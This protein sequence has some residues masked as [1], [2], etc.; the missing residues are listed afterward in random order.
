LQILDFITLSETI[1]ENNVTLKRNEWWYRIAWAFL[2]IK[3]SDGTFN[4]GR[5]LRLQL[6]RP[7]TQKVNR[8]TQ[9]SQTTEVNIILKLHTHL[10]LHEHV[11]IN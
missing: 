6:F 9:N 5:K 7:V 1:K 2:P 8:N 4:T 11:H 3:S 10:Y